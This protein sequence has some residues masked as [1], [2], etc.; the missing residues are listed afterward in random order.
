L[1]VRVVTGI[2]SSQLLLLA[3]ASC[4]G[5]AEEPPDQS[6]T[7][8]HQEKVVALATTMLTPNL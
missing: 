4:I 1:R 6:Y 7:C 3:R 8:M 5:W 2:V